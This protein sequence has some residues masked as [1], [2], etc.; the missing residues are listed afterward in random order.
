MSRTNIDLD[1]KLVRRG[2]S[3]TGF[4]TKKELVNFAL[5]ELLRME[6]QKG[7]LELEGRFRWTGNLDEM[8]K[9]RF[10]R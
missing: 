5:Q 8:R 10:K 3:I 2:L 7:L 6:E 4:R 1:D 9:N